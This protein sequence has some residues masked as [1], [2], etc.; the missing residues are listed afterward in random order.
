M[1]GDDIAFGAFCAVLVV[2]LIVLLVL[3]GVMHRRR[4]ERWRHHVR[5]WAKYNGW[6]ADFAPQVDWP[7]RL[8]GRNRRGMS[9]VLSGAIAG[10][11]VAVGNYTYTTTSTS[12]TTGPNGVISTTTTTH[13]HDFT[14]AVTWVA[15]PTP[16][17]TLHQRGAV[18]RLGRRLFGESAGATGHE[19]FDRRFRIESP[20]PDAARALF[21]PLLVAETLAGHLPLWS[22]YA[23]T[24]LAHRPGH[25][26]DPAHAPGMA[27]PLARVADLLGR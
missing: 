14:V 11:P 10:R 20:T 17:V 23:G 4:Q 18:S 13:N 9:L 26:K 3:A 6:N 21:G 27:A 19:E 8:P 2:L 24:L 1:D 7:E 22:L 5:G 25:I 16:T 12:T 15:Q